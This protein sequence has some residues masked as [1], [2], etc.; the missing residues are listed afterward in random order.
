MALLQGIGGV[1]GG[2]HGVTLFYIVAICHF[3]GGNRGARCDV[4]RNADGLKGGGVAC[5]IGGGQL[6]RGDGGIDIGVLDI[7]GGVGRFH[8][9]DVGLGLLRGD[10]GG[11]GFQLRLGVECTGTAGVI[12][13]VDGELGQGVGEGEY[14]LSILGVFVLCVRQATHVVT[15]EQVAGNDFVGGALVG[16]HG[17]GEAGLGGDA[18]GGAV[19]RGGSAV[20]RAVSVDVERS[21]V[22]VPIDGCSRAGGGGVSLVLVVGIVAVQ[23]IQGGVFGGEVYAYRC[24]VGECVARDGDMVAGIVG[25]GGYS[26]GGV[27]VE[28]ECHLLVGVSV[29]IVTVGDFVVL[30]SAQA[31]GGG[32]EGCPEVIHCF[33]VLVFYN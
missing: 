7:L 12:H 30:A 11:G 21:F 25:T 5:G 14:L 29:V 32:G 15:D 23:P 22:V 27:H 6:I 9:D 31:E 28:T 17:P 1:G 2:F 24:T 20:V 16:L 19:R 3:D 4:L 10:L 33:H 26:N 18:A 13:E 8:E